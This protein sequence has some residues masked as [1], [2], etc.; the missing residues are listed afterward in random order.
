MWKNKVKEAE[1]KDNETEDSRK[2][3]KSNLKKEEG[4]DDEG[5]E[6]EEGR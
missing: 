3:R 4:G 5:R 2:D 6:R 1:E